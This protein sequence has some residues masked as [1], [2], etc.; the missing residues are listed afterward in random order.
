MG[1]TIMA[2]K[3]GQLTGVVVDSATKAVPYV[4]VALFKKGQ[5]QPVAQTFTKPNGTFQLRVDTGAYVLALTHRSFQ[6]FSMA[7]VLEQGDNII[8]TLRLGNRQ[9][10]L[11]NVIVRTVRPLVEQTDDRIIYNA[12]NDPAAKGE[13]ATDLLRKTP[14]V[15]VDGDGNVQV[16]GQSNFRV[17]LNGR[18]TSQFALNV[19]D[20]L[21]SFPGALITRIEV[22]TAP[23]ARWDAE[24]VGGIINIITRKKIIGFNGTASAYYSTLNN[25]TKNVNFNAKQGRWGVALSGGLNGLAQPLPN[26]SISETVP[27]QTTT[28]AK[29][30]LEG[31]RNF[32]NFNKVANLEVSYDLDSFKTV[33]VYGNMGTA[34]S[35][36]TLEQIIRTQFSAQP[37]QQG[38]LSQQTN[39]VN[40]NRSAGFDF[41]RR[42][43]N[44]P[45]AEWIFR[46]NTQ[47][48]RGETEIGSTQTAQ[49]GMREVINN[50]ETVNKEHTFQIDMAQ[51]LPKKRKW[52][53]GAKTILRTA[54][55]DFSSLIRSAASDNF[56]PDPT[57][58]DRFNYR[59]NVFAAYTSINTPIGKYNLRSGVRVEHTTITGDFI[60]SAETV[61]QKFTNVVPNLLLSRK[62][63]SAYTGTFSYNLRL[64]RPSI[65]N[66]N[67]LVNN[68]DSLN[69]SFGN[70][71]LGPQTLH[72]VSLQN[73]FS[74]GKLFAV[75][76]L[77]GSYT[78]NMIIQFA[79]FNNSTGITSLSFA[80]IGRDVQFNAGLNVNGPVGPKLTLGFFS[81]VRYNRVQSRAV[82]AQL[83]EG[84]SGAAFGNFNWKVV[85]KFTISGSGG[86]TQGPYTLV[87]APIPLGFYQVNFGYR[88]F[89]EKLWAT[90]NWNNF[91]DR[92]QRF[93]QTTEDPAFR[94]VNTTISPYRVV[95]FGLTYNFGKLKE[96]VSK[97]KGVNND[98]VVQ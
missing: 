91:H 85:G 87:N 33:S 58:S 52:E 61:D 92:N 95:Y 24:G 4:T 76:S 19:K 66:L 44:K 36:T 62:F 55:A 22:I 84:W 74:K 29:R 39:A 65:S 20:A 12:E 83:R 32:Q 88:F 43:R 90:M 15:T 53:S 31:E 77:G 16:N 46:A 97:K 28:F 94:I 13:T 26:T 25:F 10:T 57:N 23:S 60:S 48:N 35:E 27:L 18:E 68:N 30:T 40:P 75:I 2:Q 45:E 17:L 96:N 5:N 89:K 6:N 86:V 56:K 42:F 8:D 69:I 37:E 38:L 81:Q 64:Q 70:P 49:Q 63:N 34:S 72:V 93:R 21:R 51:P 41:V 71:Q 82:V 7:V 50:S 98:D 67:P 54:V 59:Q 78:N 14:M 47:Y 79:S 73:R 3:S 9:M 80:N 1:H 11:A